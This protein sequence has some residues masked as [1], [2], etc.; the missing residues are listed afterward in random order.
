MLDEAGL[1]ALLAGEAAPS[2]DG[3]PSEQRE[4]SQ[5]GLDL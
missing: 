3:E 2:Q 4:V 1:R 5:M